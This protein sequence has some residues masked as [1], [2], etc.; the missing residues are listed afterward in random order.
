MKKNAALMNAA[1][2]SKAEITSFIKHSRLILKARTKKQTL[3]NEPS[4]ALF[5]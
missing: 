2:A 5:L 1:F 4:A 3:L